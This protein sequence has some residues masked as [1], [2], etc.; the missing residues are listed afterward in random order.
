MAPTSELCLILNASINDMYGANL[1]HA[2][3]S[4][5][6]RFV[7]DAD[8]LPPRPS[9]VT[10]SR[11]AGS[12]AAPSQ[13]PV[14]FLERRRSRV[15]LKRHCGGSPLRVSAN[16]TAGNR[17]QENE[18]AVTEREREREREKERKGTMPAPSARR[19]S[20]P[21]LPSLLL[22]LLLSKTATTRMLC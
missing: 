8:D 13:S 9:L 11:A 22:L 5:R 12:R 2:N 17:R 19:P 4:C 18:R 1:I 7:S 10:S 3:E 16:L 20:H 15:G 14:A 21:P 6:T